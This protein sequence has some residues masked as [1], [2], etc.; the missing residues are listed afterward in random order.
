[1]VQRKCA[2]GRVSSMMGSC[3]NCEQKKL[4]GKPLQTKLRINGSG[5]EYEQE[6]ERVAKQVMRMAHPPLRPHIAKENVSSSIQRHKVSTNRGPV[7]APSIVRDVLSSP[8]EPLDAATRAFFEPRFGHDFSRVR[9]HADAK[10]A[11][12]AREVDAFAYTGGQHVVFGRQRYAPESGPGRRLLAHELTHVVQQGARRTDSFV[13]RATG[14]DPI[15]EKDEAPVSLDTGIPATHEIV[16]NGEPFDLV[17]ISTP[18]ALKGSSA[19]YRSDV[20]KYLGDYPNLGNGAWA[21]I[22]QQDDGVLCKIGGNCL[23]WAFGTFG[24]NDPPE[25]VWGLLPQY[26]DSIGQRTRGTPLETWQ[27]QARQEKISV[28][29]IWDYFMSVNFSAS[30]TESEGEAHLALYG[31]G[32]AGTM[33]GPSHIAFRTAAGEFWVS[34]PSATKF[35]VVH[36]RSGQMS[37]GE[38]G[39]VVRHYKRESG[40]LSHV[41]VR[42]KSA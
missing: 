16:I 39:N 42:R 35:P 17:V 31:R 2:C 23:G 15:A 6:A 41:V 24:L 8:G 12:S 33:D 26:L 37:G 27:K 38:M 22:V 4:L 19:K 30:P 40:P 3:S 13:Q 18:E 7:S 21:F 32:F 10:A 29:S 1:M 28:H 34:K 36:E 25:Y 5:D 9:I 11:A 14:A 20:E